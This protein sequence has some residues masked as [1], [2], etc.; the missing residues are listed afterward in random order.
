MGMWVGIAERTQ[1]P[2]PKADTGRAIDAF[3]VG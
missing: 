1:T 3:R 2:A